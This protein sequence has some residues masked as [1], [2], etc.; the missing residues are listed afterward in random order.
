MQEIC[1]VDKE[2]LQL[3]K[4][5]RYKDIE[6]ANM[7]NID[8]EQVVSLKDTYKIKSK[9]PAIEET[10][11]RRLYEQQGLTDGEI[12]RIKNISSKT[13]SN[14]RK[15]YGI[16]TKG[17]RPKIEESELCR[18]YEEQGLTDNEIGKMKNITRST[19]GKLRKRYGIVTKDRR[20][21]VEE[22]DK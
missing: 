13:I 10:E 20:T 12:G 22:T 2:T 15:R 5:M 6:I 7:Y 19:V 8:L 17:Q 1:I 4:D 18:L 9:G 14:L 16:V 21:K 3:L 11:L